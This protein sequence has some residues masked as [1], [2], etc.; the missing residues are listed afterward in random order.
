MKRPKIEE[1]LKG[2]ELKD[3]HNLYLSCPE[4]YRHIVRLDLYIDYLEEK[5]NKKL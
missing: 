3:V 2:L 1:T 4:L 5:L